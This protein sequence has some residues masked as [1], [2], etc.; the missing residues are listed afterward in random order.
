MKYNSG[1]IDSMIRLAMRNQSVIEGKRVTKD[2]VITI[3]LHDLMV[4]QE[5]RIN[6]SCAKLC[7]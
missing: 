5:K 1:I 3:A 7:K 6:K 2:D 4:K